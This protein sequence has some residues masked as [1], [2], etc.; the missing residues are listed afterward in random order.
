[1]T[2]SPMTAAEF[3]F[4]PR[5]GGSASLSAVGQHILNF[6]ATPAR[7]AAERHRLAGLPRRYLDDAGM[8]RADL[9]VALPGMHPWFPRNAEGILSRS[10]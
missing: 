10:I 5:H 7:S 9:D 6:L 8:T 3:G 1:M 4:K 2:T